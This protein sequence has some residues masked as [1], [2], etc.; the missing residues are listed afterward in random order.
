M[1]PLLL[2]LSRISLIHQRIFIMKKTLDFSIITERPDLAYIPFIVSSYPFKLFQLRYILYIKQYNTV[3]LTKSGRTQRSKLS[4]I[5]FPETITPAA[6]QISP[7]QRIARHFKLRPQCRS[8]QQ[9]IIYIIKAN[10]QSKK[11]KNQK[12]CARSTI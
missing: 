5:S 9:W 1:C 6:D 12:I 2:I 4:L 8:C 3:S 11:G 7:K 10:R